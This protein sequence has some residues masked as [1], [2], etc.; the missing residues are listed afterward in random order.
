MRCVLCQEACNELTS[1]A[2][3]K[4]MKFAADWLGCKAASQ[5]VTVSPVAAFRPT[6]SHSALLAVSIF[7]APPNLYQSLLRAH[8][9][10]CACFCRTRMQD[11]KANSV[12]VRSAVATNPDAN[13]CKSCM[14]K[15][16]CTER[17]KSAQVPANDG[18]AAA[19]PAALVSGPARAAK[20]RP[21]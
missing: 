11:R 6:Y 21:R 3:V 15:F 12:I 16:C 20:E 1:A 13:I 8:S 4:M 9:D 10:T 19:V 2:R 14:V 18:A 5:M 17:L 7:L